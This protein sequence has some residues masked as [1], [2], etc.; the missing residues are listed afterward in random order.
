MRAKT[1]LETQYFN[2]RVWTMDDILQAIYKHHDLLPSEM[3][4]KLPLKQ[5]WVPISSTE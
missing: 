4:A 5:I 2:I 1:Y 3:E